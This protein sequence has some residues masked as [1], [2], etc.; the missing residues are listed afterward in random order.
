MLHLETPLRLPLVKQMLTDPIVQLVPRAIDTRWRSHKV[1]DLAVAG[2]NPFLNAVFYARESPLGEWLKT[3]SASARG[4]NTKDRLMRDLLLAVHDYLHVWGTRLIQQLAPEIGFG[5]V[6]I[7]RSTIEEHVFC[8]LVAEAIATVGLD[9]WCLCTFD[10]NERLPIGTRF[11]GGLTV[12]YQERHLYEFQRASPTL[13]V[14]KK[15]FFIELCR[16]YCSGKF[17]GFNATDIKE[18]PL[19]DSWLSHELSYGQLQRE[20]SRAWFC[21][22]SEENIVLSSNQRKG[23]VYSESA[24]QQ[25]LME[26]AAAALWNKVK[27]GEMMAMSGAMEPAWK[28]PAGKALDFRFRNV[29][30]L[31]E[32]DLWSAAEAASHEQFDFGFS[33]IVSRY[34]YGAFDPVLIKLFPIV[35]EKKDMALL[36]A[37]LRG[38]L[39]L[40][41]SDGEPEDLL[42]IN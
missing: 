37:V 18:S 33:Q 16:F 41:K 31:S 26:E 36:R 21:Y 4:F 34:D 28:S 14:Q 11:T 5:R 35:R 38:Q 15:E 12:P 2:F 40:P 20:I 22:L 8:Q 17:P 3:P 9:Y 30:V 32:V 19:L 10:L 42:M 23:P 6:K 1:I 25:R 39:M 24:W 7:T 13:C 27:Q 29:N